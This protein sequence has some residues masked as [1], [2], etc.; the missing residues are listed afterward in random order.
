[1][2]KDPDFAMLFKQRIF[3]DALDGPLDA[4]DPADP[5]PRHPRPPSRVAGGAP[6][7]TTFVVT[8]RHPFTLFTT[9]GQ[10]PS[11]VGRQ[12]K[13]CFASEALQQIVLAWLELWRTVW[14]V[15]AA[16]PSALVVRFEDLLHRP[17]GWGELGPFRAAVGGCCAGRESVRGRADCHSGG[18]GRR[19]FGGAWCGAQAG[20][21]V[22]EH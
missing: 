14:A 11:C 9:A 1:M 13:A 2:A 22:S 21:R 20:G 15:L 19:H 17:A 18:V 16:L 3:G 4:S 5:P 12:G 7:N 6:F 10:Q 8:M